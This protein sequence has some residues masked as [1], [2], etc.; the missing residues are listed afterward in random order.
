MK[1]ERDDHRGEAHRFERRLRRH[2]AATRAAAWWEALWASLWPLPAVAGLFVVLALF[3]LLPLLG[4]W[5]HAVVLAGFALAVGLCLA[6]FARRFRPPTSEAVERRLERVSGLPHRP[7]QALA[8]SPTG[9]DEGTF[10][11]WRAH[12]AMMRARLRRTR[13]DFPRSPLP[14]R[15]PRALRAAVL[16][17]ILIGGIAA[18][19]DVEPRLA[20]AV[21]P[22]LTGAAT[23]DLALDLWVQP[24]SY[25]GAAPIY[26]P[27]QDQTLRFPAGSKVVA[28]INGR[29]RGAPE[30]LIDDDAVPL[31]AVDGGTY[32]ITHPVEAGETLAVRAGQ[33]TLGQW[34]IAVVPD[35]PPEVRLARAPTETARGALRLDYEARDD[36]GIAALSAHFRPSRT[37][38]EPERIAIPIGGSGRREIEGT[39]FH[40]LTSHRWAGRE[41]DLWLTATDAAEQTG[42]SALVRMTL[43][44]R[45]FSHPVAR[46]IIEQR[47]RLDEPDEETKRAVSDA[48]GAIAERAPLYDHDSVV[49]L[50]LG[51]SQW[52][53]RRDSSEVSVGQVRDILWDT[54]LRLEDGGLSLAERELRAAQQAL[55]EALAEGASDEEIERL[56][57]E[58]RRAIEQFAMSLMEQAGE[59]LEDVEAMSES[60]QS[61]ETRE[62]GDMLDRMRELIQSGARDAAQQL[63][64]ELQQ[65]LE[66]IREAR[67][68]A[69]DD[70]ATRQMRE[71][72][73]QLR[74][75]AG[76]QQRLL[77]ET[78][79]E[80]QQRGQTGGM[81]ERMQQRG[82]PQQGWPPLPGMP[83]Q[84]GGE[85]AMPRGD[86]PAPGAGGEGDQSMS[87]LSSRQED[88]RR[89]LGEMM[90]QLGEATGQIPGGLGRAERAMR[91][92][93][94]E[95]D[96][97]QA[98][99]AVG[100]QS[101]ALE[102]LQQAGRAMGREL[103]RQLGILRGQQGEQQG[104]G[105]GRADPLGRNDGQSLETEGVRVPDEWELQRARQIRDELYRRSGERAR[106]D[107]ERE[108]FDR[109]LDRF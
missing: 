33:R 95:L 25:T 101:E 17:M 46:A 35:E 69:V 61:I 56:I 51:V 29:P 92:A 58:L 90:R 87:G 71:M 68:S 9:G 62:L 23:S 54:A 5:M 49:A 79:R 76:R 45:T 74:D 38:T 98:G 100:E 13:G 27:Q 15:D 73:E 70:A 31:D 102:H 64:A 24:P 42:R 32:E 36:Y 14:A 30:L 67:M 94:G 6:G 2:L 4:G 80:A 12:L 48:L 59:D 60:A 57:D 50:A 72:M 91:G 93:V 3:D 43:P 83:G 107:F 55:M 81:R 88:L 97:G 8:D 109:L 37:E 22:S 18:W 104:D 103:A 21:T 65:M 7:L 108:Y 47:K 66:S 85:Q 75:M 106:P 52:R 99:A 53:L 16:I 1:R 78:Y 11:A 105:W 10:A 26:A 34:T 84:R 20:R 39:S 96:S 41:V 44:E 86:Q 82:M 40:D 28:R 77:D 19:G 63:L 89:M